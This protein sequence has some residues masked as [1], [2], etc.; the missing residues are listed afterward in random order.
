MHCLL[1]LRTITP[2]GETIEGWECADHDEATR[3]FLLKA[4][5]QDSLDLIIDWFHS[6]ET[7]AT[8]RKEYAEYIFDY[9][10]VA[11]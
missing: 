8:L 7:S 10:E 4:I 6:S 5:Y 1:T 2:A 9:T 11:A 3:L